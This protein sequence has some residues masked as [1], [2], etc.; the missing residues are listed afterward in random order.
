MR[1]PDQE[2]RRPGDKRHA[3]FIPSRSGSEA[4]EPAST[5]ATPDNSRHAAVTH[6]RLISKGIRLS[7]PFGI[8][9]A[10][11]LASARDVFVPFAWIGIS[12]NSARTHQASATNSKVL[13]ANADSLM[14][15]TPERYQYE[16]PLQ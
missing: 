8:S 2:N 16:L 6:R 10:K 11:V 12:M 9:A 7:P 4:V 15:T 3:G 1:I 5:V 14:G 13:A